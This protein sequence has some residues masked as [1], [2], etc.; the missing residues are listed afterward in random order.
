MAVYRF[1]VFIEDDH[2]VYRDIE[3]QGKQRFADLHEAVVKAFNFKTGQPAEY[4]SS[5]QSWYEGDTVVELDE[6]LEGD[7]QKIAN[8]IFDP[9]QRFLCVTESYN[10]VG[11]A[12]ELQK[13]LKDEDGATYPRCIRSEG[14]PPYYTQPPPEPIVDEPEEEEVP[15]ME[16]DMFE[17]DGP[18][19]E[20]I[21][22]IQKEAEAAAKAGLLKAPK[23]NV[24]K[25]EKKSEDKGKKKEEGF[26]DFDMDDLM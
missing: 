26:G 19:E 6:N 5:D 25:L 23:V 11:L 15:D 13:I 18:S 4:I 21:E 22:R 10:E 3:L 9:H 20:E 7:H 24:S 16:V 1:R 12:L 14:A 2:E 8:H 17:G